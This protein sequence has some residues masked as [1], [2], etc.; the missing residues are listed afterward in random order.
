MFVE[1]NTSEVF[2]Q[3]GKDPRA[4]YDIKERLAIQLCILHACERQYAAARAKSV[5]FIADRTPIDLASYMLADVQRSC[6]VGNPAVARAINSYVR[7][8][9]DATNQWFSTVVLVQPGIP[10]VEQVGKAPACPAF[11]EHISALQ[12]GLLVDEGLKSRHFFIPRRFTSLKD[13]I[14]CLSS[15][16]NGAVEAMVQVQRLREEAGVTIH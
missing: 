5:I 13:R 15:A 11:I 7:Q 10:L 2:R 4:E 3:L 8:C 14:D 9:I 6:L 1:T 16:T 12:M